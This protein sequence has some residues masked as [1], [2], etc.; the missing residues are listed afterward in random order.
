MQC[1]IMLTVGTFYKVEIYKVEIYKVEI[2]KVE[3]YKVEIGACR[4]L[5]EGGEG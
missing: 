3:I 1:P 5:T 2:Y 4:L